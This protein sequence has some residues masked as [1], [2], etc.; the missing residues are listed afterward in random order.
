MTHYPRSYYLLQDKSIFLQTPK[1]KE[2]EQAWS[3]HKIQVML[4]KPKKVEKTVEESVS[5]EYHQYLKVFSK[6]ESER[7]PIRKP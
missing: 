1:K 5:K 4:D 7:M 2:V 3:A 6:E